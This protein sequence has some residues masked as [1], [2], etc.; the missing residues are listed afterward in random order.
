MYIY[1]LFSVIDFGFLSNL[2]Y[3]SLFPQQIKH[4]WNSDRFFLGGGLLIIFIIRKLICTF[5]YFYLVPAVLSVF[6]RCTELLNEIKV[7]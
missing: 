4:L 3:I 2:S 7:T 1:L 5:S 6:D